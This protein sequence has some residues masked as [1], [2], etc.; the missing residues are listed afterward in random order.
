MLHA[1]AQDAIRKH[2]SANAGPRDLCVFAN[3]VGG[4]E[5]ATEIQTLIQEMG[6]QERCWFSIGLDTPGAVCTDVFGNIVS[7]PADKVAEWLP[8]A[9]HRSWAWQSIDLPVDP[10]IT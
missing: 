5:D 1:V 3:N 7:P 4:K 2:V 6:L 10:V 9:P 8:T